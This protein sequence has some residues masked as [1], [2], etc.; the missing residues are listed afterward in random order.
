LWT[1]KRNHTPSGQDEDPCFEYPLAQKLLFTG[2]AAVSELGCHPG[3][4]TPELPSTPPERVSARDRRRCHRHSSRCCHCRLLLAWRGGGVLLGIAPHRCAGETT[5]FS[6]CPPA[7][8]KNES[9]INS[10][11]KVYWIMR[12]KRQ[13]LPLNQPRLGVS[14]IH[15]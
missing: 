7:Y 12:S 1:W 13:N 4:P 9:M 3:E 14:G 11:E 10:L 8:G 2:H 15:S 5:V 6:F